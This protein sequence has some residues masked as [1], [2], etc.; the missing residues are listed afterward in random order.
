[1][2]KIV[3]SL[4]VFMVF[5]NTYAQKI[6]TP[7]LSS[8]A[9]A[10]TN[11]MPD[12]FLDW[13]A[14]SGGLGLHYEIALD[15]NQSF[16]DPIVY[17][18][19]STAINAEE[20]LFGE[21]YYWHVRAIDNYDTSY[22]STAR[23]F[24]V[25]DN[26]SLT[27]PA[28]SATNQN[29]NVTIDWAGTM[30]GIT[31]YDYELDTSA[32]FD[33]S[34]KWDGSTSS[35]VSQATPSN[36]L[37]GTIYYWHVRARHS[38]DTSSWCTA[39]SF[40]TRDTF[41]L[42]TP[43]DSALNQSPNVQLK[44]IGVPGI[45]YYKFELDTAS[46]FDSPL[47]YEEENDS[48]FI[49]CQE[50]MFG[51]KYYWRAIGR[52]S[53]DTTSW[54]SVRKFTVTDTLILSSP[55]NSSTNVS[56]KP[57]LKWT[58]IAGVSGFQLQY[59]TSS[60]F[61]D[62][63][64]EDADTNLYEITQHLDTSEVYYWRVRAFHSNDTTEWSAIWSFTTADGFSGINNVDVENNIALYPNPCKGK[65]ILQIQYANTA[66]AKLKVMDILGQSVFEKE[67][68]ISSGINKEEINL[69]SLKEGIYLIRLQ[70][71]NKTYTRKLVID[72]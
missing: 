64:I 5:F 17:S 31:N 12:V 40:T 42:Y 65:L 29:P 34:L 20:L 54:S 45:L 67:M 23:N 30:T 44:S 43:A 58:T 18:T 26:V 68:S 9:N 33:S 8:P 47:L 55:A 63:V 22:W 38:V 50:L 53:E 21:T 10:A 25:I 11:Q 57:T 32:N 71:G 69:S 4:C 14:V 16:T 72:K 62:P 41:N 51:Y 15:T 52:H 6:Y 3:F 24:T 28:N 49:K 70:E 46:S 39:R 1:M 56:T 66:D 35:A 48:N 27:S 59:D 36:L 2:K 61:T 13:G 19:S 37:F 60:G 7:T